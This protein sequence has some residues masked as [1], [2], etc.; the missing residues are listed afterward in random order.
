MCGL[1]CSDLVEQAMQALVRSLET[2]LV[3]GAFA[4][5]QKA[6]WNTNESVVAESE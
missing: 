3:V 2:K 4:K 1:C 5:M 6:S